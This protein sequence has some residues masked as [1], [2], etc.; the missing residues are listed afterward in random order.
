VTGR[1][2]SKRRSDHY[3]SA[4]FVR[5]GGADTIREQLREIADARRTT[6][7]EALRQVVAEAYEELE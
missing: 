4:Q 3:F 5:H 6:I 7:S 2:G 1:R